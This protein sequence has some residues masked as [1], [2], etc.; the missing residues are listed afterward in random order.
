M[1]IR[2]RAKVVAVNSSKKTITVQTTAK[3]VV[4]EEDDDVYAQLV[5]Q[6]KADD[7]VLVVYNSTD[8][9]VSAALPKT[10]TGVVTNYTN[11]AVLTVDGVDYKPSDCGFAD[12]TLKAP[13]AYT[14]LLYTSRCV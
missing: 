13:A 5:G 11:K 6:V 14:C 7:Y 1:C 4:L 3:N 2:D 9:I 12:T 10:V 8:G